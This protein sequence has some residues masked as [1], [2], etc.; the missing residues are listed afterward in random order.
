V[1]DQRTRLVATL[2]Q[3]DTPRARAGWE[4]T[5]RQHRKVLRQLI[6]QAGQRAARELAG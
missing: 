5:A 4:L 6:D 3:L 2:V 1:F